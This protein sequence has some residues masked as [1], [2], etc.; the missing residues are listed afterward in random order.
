MGGRIVVPEPDA[1]MAKTIKTFML[2]PNEIAQF[3]KIFQ[4]LDKSKI[5]LISIDAICK[6]IECKRSAVVDSLLEL[7]EIEHEGELNFS[8]FLTMVVTLC[9][10]DH[11]NMLKFCF[12]M[13]DQGII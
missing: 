10:F 11:V 7:L 1:K 4:K 8:D 12:F 13:F 9:M 5:G 3:W 2:T 6:S